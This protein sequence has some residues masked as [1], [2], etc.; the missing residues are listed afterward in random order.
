MENSDFL[1]RL[2]AEATLQARLHDQRF[3]PPQLDVLTSF[4]GRQAWKVLVFLAI[5]TSLSLEFLKKM[6]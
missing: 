4:I 5:I 3:F 2:Q 6:S 1:S